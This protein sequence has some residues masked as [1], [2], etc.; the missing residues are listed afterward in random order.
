MALAPVTTCSE[1]KNGGSENVVKF[2]SGDKGEAGEKGRTGD[3]GFPGPQVHFIII[4]KFQ[5]MI[6]IILLK[7]QLCRWFRFA[8]LAKGKKFR[9]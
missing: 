3:F 1:L 9:P 7:I 5:N 6:F 2:I 8:Q 4:S